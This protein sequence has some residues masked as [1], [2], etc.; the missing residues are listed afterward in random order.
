MCFLSALGKTLSSS[1]LRSPP[2]LSISWFSKAPCC[3][4]RT[5]HRPPESPSLSSV[6]WSHFSL[7]NQRPSLQK[8][9]AGIWTVGLACFQDCAGHC[10]TDEGSRHRAQDSLLCPGRE[11]GRTETQSNIAFHTHNRRLTI[12][13]ISS[14]W[15]EVNTL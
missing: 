5:E 2:V 13:V 6:Y 8:L 9:E 1:V 14:S 10:G 15:A 4:V 11:K 12:A 7:L 3:S